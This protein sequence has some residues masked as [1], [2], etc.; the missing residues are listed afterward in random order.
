MTKLFVS[1]FSCQ[2]EGINL[3]IKSYSDCNA[4]S[5]NKNVLSYLEIEKTEKYIKDWFEKFDFINVNQYVNELQFTYRLISH[6]LKLNYVYLQLM[7]VKNCEQEL[8]FLLN[9]IKSLI[10]E[11]NHI[12]HYR[13]K[14]SDYLYSVKRLEILEF[15]YENLLKLMKI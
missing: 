3:D 5:N 12:W 6:S 14:K 8:K 2:T 1:F 13:N 7:N 15:K 4:L 9:D 10:F 11:Y